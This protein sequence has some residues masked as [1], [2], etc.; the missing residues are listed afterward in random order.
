MPCRI[1]I[2]VKQKGKA[3][4]FTGLD[5]P[6]GFQEVKVLHPPAL[7]MEPIEGSETSAFRTRTPGNYLKENILHKVPSSRDNGTEW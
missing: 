4:P 1:Q 7:K 3:L 6:R 5:S 2:I